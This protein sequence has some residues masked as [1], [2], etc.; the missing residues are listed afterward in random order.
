M[1]AETLF[2]PFLFVL[3]VIIQVVFWFGF[4]VKQAFPLWKIPGPR[5]AAFSRLWLS[6]VLAS[7]DSAKKL[8][9]VNQQYGKVN[10]PCLAALADVTSRSF[11]PYRTKPSHHQ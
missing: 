8:L 11:S 10:S 2:I 4:A 3:C 5:C 9:E 6:K 7:G 1:A